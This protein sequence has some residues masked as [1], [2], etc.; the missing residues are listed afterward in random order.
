MDDIDIL[1][2]VHLDQ[3]DPRR[4]NSKHQRNDQAVVNTIH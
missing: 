1:R 4:N 3:G 2:Y